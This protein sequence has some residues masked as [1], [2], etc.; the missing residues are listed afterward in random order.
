MLINE[1]TVILNIMPR[2]MATVYAVKKFSGRLIP[3]RTKFHV[4]KF[5]RN[6]NSEITWQKLLPH[7]F[8]NVL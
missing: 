6:Y 1:V 7:R 8:D 3:Q 4:F 2:K 5:C